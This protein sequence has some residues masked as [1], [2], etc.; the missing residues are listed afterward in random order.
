MSETGPLPRGEKA[1]PGGAAAHG[2]TL[3]ANLLLAALKLVV[4][5]LAGSPAL[6]ADGWHSVSDVGMNVLAWAGYRAAQAPPD[7]DHHYGHGN[8]EAVAGLVVGLTVIA[9]GVAVV[10]SIAL[11]GGPGT[12][13]EHGWLALGAGLA[14]GATKLALARYTARVGTRLN[15]PSL[16]AVSRDN[17]SDALTG[18]LVPVAIGASLAGLPWAERVLAGIIGLVIGWMG[19]KSAREGLDILM[20]RVADPLLRGRLRDLAAAVPG[21][22]DVQS[23]RVHPLGSELRIDMEISVDPDWTVA[24]GHQTAHDV[25]RAIIEAQPHVWEVHVHVNPAVSGSQDAGLLS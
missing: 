14:A 24:R 9:A 10:A 23:V 25:E 11:Q 6:L 15:S 8:W 17:L 7:E 18:A 22:I 13:P 21:V 16:L 3:A 1:A 4:G 19:L 5:G 12:D 2:V 20:D